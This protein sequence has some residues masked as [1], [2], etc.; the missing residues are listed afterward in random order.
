MPTLSCKH[1]QHRRSSPSAHPLRLKDVVKDTMGAIFR[2][3]LKLSYL[4]DNI[5]KATFK[6]FCLFFRIS[7]PLSFSPVSTIFPLSFSFFFFFFSS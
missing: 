4:E 1:P 2:E 3:D 6:S 5:P 7:I